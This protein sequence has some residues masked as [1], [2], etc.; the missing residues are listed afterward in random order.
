M[1]MPLAISNYSWRRGS[2]SSF[3]IGWIVLGGGGATA[4]TERDGAASNLPGTS[5][6][7]SGDSDQ[8]QGLSDALLASCETRF[9]LDKIQ[10]F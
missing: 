3:D 7:L 6:L 1:I 4:F 2:H 9:I 10:A 5:P 8:K